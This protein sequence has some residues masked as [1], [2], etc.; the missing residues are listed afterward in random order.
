MSYIL[1]AL[2]KLEEKRRSEAGPNFLSPKH[3]DRQNRKMH[4]PWRYVIAFGLFLNLV[5]FL[6]ALHPWRSEKALEKEPG[7]AV[8]KTQ[9]RRGQ[10]MGRETI[11][12]GPGTGGR[13]LQPIMKTHEGRPAGYDDNVSAAPSQAPRPSSDDKPGKTKIISMSELPSSVRQKL[14]DLSISGHFYESRPAGRV[15][16]VGGRILR[17]GADVA[18]GITLERI[19]PDG[20][21]FSCDGLLFHKG[22]F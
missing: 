3:S 4:F 9:V 17:E 8:R 11:A 20:A 15:V 19:T 14:P 10:D 16:T 1:E 13:Q 18:P 22:V 12:E 7:N 6:W 2:K 5:I 21:V